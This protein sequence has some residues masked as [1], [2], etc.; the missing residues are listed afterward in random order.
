MFHHHI[1]YSGRYCC[2]IAKAF[3]YEYNEWSFIPS[4]LCIKLKSILWLQSIINGIHTTFSGIRSKFIRYLE[5]VKKKKYRQYGW[6]RNFNQPPP[7]T[8]EKNL[9]K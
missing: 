2:N 5:K 4:F 1:K 6:K 3:G 8:I 7:Y 9:E